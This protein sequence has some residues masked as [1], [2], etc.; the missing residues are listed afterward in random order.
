MYAIIDY[1]NIRILRVFKQ[2]TKM[3]TVNGEIVKVPKSGLVYFPAGTTINVC[4]MLHFVKHQ[5]DTA[6]NKSILHNNAIIEKYGLSC[7]SIEIDE[8]EKI[9]ASLELTEKI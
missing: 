4:K 2:N 6:T 5:I 8:N 7:P 9:L 3:F 1:E